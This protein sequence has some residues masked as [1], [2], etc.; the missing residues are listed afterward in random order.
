MVVQVLL[1]RWTQSRRAFIAKIS[2]LGFIYIR[3]EYIFE[4]HNGNIDAGL[5]M[6]KTGACNRS[7]IAE[8]NQ[9]LKQVSRG[10]KRENELKGMKYY[11]LNSFG[12]E[13]RSIRRQPPRSARLHSHTHLHPLTYA[14]ILYIDEQHPIRTGEHIV[15]SIRNLGVQILNR[16]PEKMKSAQIRK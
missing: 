5:F 4:D 14:R 1:V 3:L 2:I 10:I 9:N 12:D 11:D 13:P 15:S 6:K 8:T 7:M 16:R